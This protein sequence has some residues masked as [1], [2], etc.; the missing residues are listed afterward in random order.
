MWWSRNSW[1]RMP[2]NNLGCIVCSSHEQGYMVRGGETENCLPVVNLMI[3]STAAHH[4]AMGNLT[5]DELTIHTSINQTDQCCMLTTLTNSISNGCIKRWPAAIQDMDHFLSP[6]QNK[7]LSSPFDATA[8]DTLC[9]CKY[10]CV[11]VKERLW[12]KIEIKCLY[13]MCVCDQTSH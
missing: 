4:K 8:I 7:S 5:S 2:P 9:W 3:N 12:R 13:C 1:G 10:V 6:L 11:G